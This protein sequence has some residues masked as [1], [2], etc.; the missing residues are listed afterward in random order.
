MI[1]VCKNDNSIFLYVCA[2]VAQS[3]SMI[4][5]SEFVKSENCQKRAAVG[6][7]P[8]GWCIL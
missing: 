3:H 2:T 4:I 7:C 8:T 1:H 5:K 6:F